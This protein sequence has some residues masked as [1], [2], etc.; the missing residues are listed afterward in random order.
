VIL[1]PH[2]TE[3]LVAQ[4][5]AASAAG[6][7]I[8][9]VDVT[10][11][12]QLLEHKPEDMTAT[13][14]AGMTL[15]AFQQLLHRA[16]QWLPIDPPHAETLT[17]A[18]LLA[19]DLSGSRRLGYGTI[20]DYLIGI[21]VALPEG[22]LIKAGGKV[23]KNVAGYDLCKLFVGARHSLGII[24]EA[25]FK[26]RPVPESEAFVQAEFTSLNELDARA[27]ALLSSA[28]EPVLLDAHNFT[29]KYTLVAA[30]AGVREDVDFQIAM[31]T[32]LGLMRISTLPTHRVF[33]SN[34]GPEK[35]S[36][37]PSRTS[38]TI[39]AMPPA[40]FLAHLGN[41]IIYFRGGTPPSEKAMP[42]KLMERVKDAYDPRRILP[43]YSA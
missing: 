18:D 30:F 43:P 36:V 41:G 35:L 42:I 9:R 28:A 3:D 34:P 33:W 40:E 2:S 11:I 29:G 27:K 7:K 25:T 24:V 31:A 38:E 1:Q 10:N 17:I 39:H 5:A 21:K 22:Q 16:G 12:S 26:L 6:T 15:A 37:L 20:R 13:V 19:C 8:T 4:L 23:V 32:S 14:Q